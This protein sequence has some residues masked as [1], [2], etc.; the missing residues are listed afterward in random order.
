VFAAPK[1]CA[2]A[3]V[4]ATLLYRGL[5]LMLARE[6]GWLEDA[7]DAVVVVATAEASVS[8]P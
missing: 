1:G 3:K 4:K 8:L 6:R 7:T 5:P 2:T